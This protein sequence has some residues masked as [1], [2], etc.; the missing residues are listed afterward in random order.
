MTSHQMWERCTG[1][2]RRLDSGTIV[3]V[4][5][6]GRPLEEPVRNMA[7]WKIG[8]YGTRK[9]AKTRDAN[10]LHEQGVWITS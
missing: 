1:S 5:T 2:L 4:K 8:I 6:K 3:R 7:S 9:T 10:D